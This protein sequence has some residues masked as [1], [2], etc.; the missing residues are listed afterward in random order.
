MNRVLT[1]LPGN[2]RC[3]VHLGADEYLSA[4]PHAHAPHY[5]NH[6]ST[7][8]GPTLYV[9]YVKA[10]QLRGCCWMF[11]EQVM[12][13]QVDLLRNLRQAKNWLILRLEGRSR[14]ARK[15]SE[16]TTLLYEPRH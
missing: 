1:S 6:D 15:S 10:G 13:L 14:G 12:Q 11:P 16:L 4:E 8:V 7:L 2:N 3:C 5:Q 9:E